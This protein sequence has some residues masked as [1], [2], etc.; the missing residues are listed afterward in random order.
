[1]ANILSVD[2]IRGAGG[3]TID[4][5]KSRVNMAGHIIQIV[6]G[7][8]STSASGT[9]AVGTN[10]YDDSGL[11]ARITPSSASSKILV[12]Y[13]MCAS[14]FNGYSGKTRIV[15]N[16]T[17][18]GLGVQQGTRSVSTS[19]AHTYYSVAGTSVHH[20]TLHANQYLDTPNTTSEITYKIQVAAYNTIGWGVNR[21]ANYQDGGTQGYDSTPISTLTLMEIG[22]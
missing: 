17:P 8:L 21:S 1:M 6:Q 5:T 3:A 20:V 22:G 4:L 15:R 16:N 2:Q 9:T 11:L 19:S 18:I 13:N 12:S 10:T 14:S 7:V